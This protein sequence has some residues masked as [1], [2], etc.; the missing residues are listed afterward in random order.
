MTKIIIPVDL[1]WE[2][3]QCAGFLVGLWFEHLAFIYVHVNV[4]YCN[5]FLFCLF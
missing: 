1:V 2:Q 5:L 4:Q 3:S